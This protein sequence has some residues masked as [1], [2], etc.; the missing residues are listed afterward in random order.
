M[1]KTASDSFNP[2][3]SSYSHPRE[4]G[5]FTRLE[6]EGLIDES[7][8]A[9]L[10]PNQ[11]VS[12]WITA[13]MYCIL[14][15]MFFTTAL[16]WVFMA[17]ATRESFSN[18][19]GVFVSLLALAVGAIMAGHFFRPKNRVRRNLQR[20]PD[21]LGF[22]RGEITAS[23]LLVHHQ[24]KDHWFDTV[25]V[26]SAPYS[27][28]GIRFLLSADPYRYIALTS[29]HFS[30]FEVR[31]FAAIHQEA[32]MLNLHREDSGKKTT[33]G[34]FQSFI[35]PPIDAVAFEGVVSIDVP[36]HTKQQWRA[37]CV[38][39]VQLILAVVLVPLVFRDQILIGFVMVVC[40]AYS[41]GSS[42][43]KLWK[44]YFVGSYTL[45]WSHSGWINNDYLLIKQD[46]SATRVHLDQLQLLEKT[47]ERVLLLPPLSLTSYYIL[48][49]NFKSPEDWHRVSELLDKRFFRGQGVE[50]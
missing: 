12:F 18:V 3:A 45:K 32:M 41:L 31:I 47:N 25:Y 38:R 42:V 50:G 16:L 44:Q 35:E 22:F 8:Y 24:G 19:I 17:T 27:E 10:M 11:S 20:Y 36:T 5:D 30:Y 34:R 39:S 9:A 49:S 48:A 26:A 43:Y 13:F 4:V 33:N 40:V 7:D 23:G 37:A 21:L 6:F 29:R 14:A 46:D 28:A 1:N 15:P 2:Y